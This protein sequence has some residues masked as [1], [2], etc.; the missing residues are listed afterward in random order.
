MSRDTNV[1]QPFMLH[2]PMVQV[3]FQP[4]ICCSSSEMCAQVG[5]SVAV[6]PPNGPS[7]SAVEVCLA[8]C[9]LCLQS[10]WSDSLLWLVTALPIHE[11][12]GP[13]CKNAVQERSLLFRKPSHMWLRQSLTM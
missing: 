8:T 3:P 10:T 2:L 5:L 1:A 4:G 12:S 13:T 9:M 11:K 6:R 7:A